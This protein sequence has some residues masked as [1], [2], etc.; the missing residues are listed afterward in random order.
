MQ[1]GKVYSAQFT[2][3][4]DRVEKVAVKLLRVKASKSDREEFLSEAELMLLLAHPKVL[5][6]WPWAALMCRYCQQAVG[7]CVARKPWLLVTEYMNYKDL[8]FELWQCVNHGLKLRI[9]ECLNFAVQ[10]LE[11]LA[12]IASVCLCCRPL[13]LDKQSGRKT[14]CTVTSASATCLWATTTASRLATLACPRS[15]RSASLSGS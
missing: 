14:S 4:D 11:G 1:F 2:D 9:H 10:M 13:S 5:R 15:C 7:V 8:G 12:F 6:V 3:D